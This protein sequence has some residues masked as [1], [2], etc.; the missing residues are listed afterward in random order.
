MC[1]LEIARGDAGELQ[2]LEPSHQL[3]HT[4]VVLFLVLLE[5][6]KGEGGGR[7]TKRV[8][9]T[10]T[11]THTHTVFTALYRHTHTGVYLGGGGGAFA[12]LELFLP[13]P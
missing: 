7:E 3:L 5:A 11:H 12:P 9:M 4:P 1:V 13:P 6:A 8:C 10:R 2:L